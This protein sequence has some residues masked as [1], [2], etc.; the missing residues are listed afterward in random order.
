MRKPIIAGN[1]K[2]FKN[3]KETRAM[4]TE[5]I[6]LVKE[7]AEREIVV[8]PPFI[9][10]EP[11]VGVCKG[12]NVKIGSQ[13]IFW[14]EKGAFTGE[15]SPGMIKDSGCEYAIIG[16]SER[17]QYF[18]E[19]DATVNKRLNA[20]LKVGLIPI[21]CVGETLEER[22]KNRT[23]EV[24]EKQLKGGLSGLL[25]EQALKTVIAY[26]PVWAIGTGKTASPA[27]AQEVH[28]FIRKQLEGLF[29]KD[30][31]SSIRI[32]YG[33]SV[34]ADNIKELMSQEDVDGGLVGGASLEAAGF[35][36]IINF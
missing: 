23:F 15:I 35:S 29:G 27:Q 5:L 28:A 8:C 36:K 21:V 3:A 1:W 19:T 20:A 24:I 25:K 12:T 16:H 9:D 17:R 7:A 14:E 30:V 22:E 34:K 26:E 2:M 32:L 31:S 11:A 6:P 33:G 10:I 4:L 18:G 13:N